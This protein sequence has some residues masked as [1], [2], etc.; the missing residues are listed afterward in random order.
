[1]TNMELEIQISLLEKMLQQLKKELQES[2]RSKSYSKE[3]REIKI[4]DV[5]K[6]VVD[7]I[8]VKRGLN[9]YDFLIEEIVEKIED[10]GCNLYCSSC[11]KFSKKYSVVER[12]IRTVKFNVF[13]NK[14]NTLAKSIFQEKEVPT[15]RK[16]IEILTDYVR[17]ILNSEK[18]LEKIL[19]LNE[20][21]QDENKRFI[22]NIVDQSLREI[23]V[24][25]K[26]NGF[27]F[28]EEEIIA[29][30]EQQYSKLYWSAAQKYSTSYYNVNAGIK[31][32]KIK[33]FKEPQSELLKELF[34]DYDEIPSNK[35]FI[36][37]IVGYIEKK[38]WQ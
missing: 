38:V 2:K 36:N 20:E 23:G 34:S 6:E 8:V 4:S 28:L 22:K 18:P 30:M 9:G 29:M 12:S 33:A 16:F 25:L 37:I 13:N 35:D 32:A 24:S 19:K 1:M 27:G 31:N 11:R 17:E 3:E 10:P 21:E 5:T 14:E 7:A 15:N 26:L